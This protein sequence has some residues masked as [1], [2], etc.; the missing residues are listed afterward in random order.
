[1]KHLSFKTIVTQT[2]LILAGGFLMQGFQCASSGVTTAKQ[3]LTKAEQANNTLQFTGAKMDA[4]KKQKTEKDKTDNYRKA[5]D[6]L[7]AEVRLLPT[8]GE[9]WHL[10]GK[11]YMGLGG[12][13]NA[14]STALAFNKSLQLNTDTAKPATK[15]MREEAAGMIYQTWGNYFNEAV[16]D[17]NNAPAEASDAA[18]TAKF[19]S[20]LRNAKKA[21]EIKPENYDVYQIEALVY[22]NIGR[23]AEAIETFERS[24]TMQKPATDFLVAKQLPIGTSREDALA[25]LGA[26]KSSK[27]VSAEPDTCVMDRYSADGKDIYLF[28]P[29]NRETG[30]FTLQGIKANP[31][32]SWMP[33]ERER[34]VP[35]DTRS[36]SYIAYKNYEKKNYDKSLEQIEL[37]LALDPTNENA[38]NIQNEILRESG[39]AD[40]AAGKVAQMVQKF[41]NNAGYRIQYAGVLLTQRKWQDAINQYDEA[42]KLDPKNEI[43]LFNSGAAY[44]NK[45]GEIQKDEFEKRDKSIEVA[46]KDKKAK[47]YE[48]N[49][50]AYMGDLEKSADY[51]NRLRTLPGKDRDFTLIENLVNI[52]TVLGKPKESEKKRLMAE[53][54]AYESMNTDKP[55]YWE[56][57]QRL[58]A[59]EAKAILDDA[60]PALKKQ[61][62]EYNT[63]AL[64]AF[65]KAEALRKK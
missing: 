17:F 50:K 61:K 9:A 2:A 5:I 25:S 26:P 11:S 37:A 33:Y 1:M 8:N 53:L 57:M 54:V 7:T 60:S 23:G 3:Y 20:A 35:F 39:K 56:T 52:Y 49:D 41:P 38:M 43:A 18:K 31:P 48:V 19:N 6:V 27:G 14:D 32:A 36:L 63:K 42:L 34:F 59:A 24:Y 46:K 28:Y 47:V 29:K 30:K 51:F 64:D 44:K 45:A 40:Q 58:Y 13:D 22:E 12:N 4:A 55:E 15:M 16:K 21:I 62:G 65:N 10:L